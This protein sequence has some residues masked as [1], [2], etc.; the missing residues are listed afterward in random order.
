ML[1]DN[2]K[3]KARPVKNEPFRSGT[4]LRMPSQAARNVTRNK[5]SSEKTSNYRGFLSLAERVQI[6][7]GLIGYGYLKEA[8]RFCNCGRRVHKFRPEGMPVAYGIKETCKSR[9]CDRCAES[10]FRRFR[11]KGLDIISTLPRDGK[12]RVVFLTLTFKTRPLSKAYIRGCEKSVRKFVNVF[13]GLWLHRYNKKTGRHSKT[14]N[15]VSCG[16]VGVLEIG[17]SDNVHFHLLAYGYFHPIKFMSKIW[18]RITGDSYRI[19]VREVSQSTKDSPRLAISYI[20]KYIRKPPRF[21]SP[22]DYA[23]YLDLLKGIRRLHT[24]GVFYAHSGWQRDREPFECPFT[25]EKLWYDGAASPGEPVLSY[26][27]V[28][29]EV[30]RARSPG[31]LFELLKGVL[32]ENSGVEDIETPA[33]NPAFDTAKYRSPEHQTE[34]PVSRSWCYRSQ[35]I[36]LDTLL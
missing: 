28:A 24:Y 12:R 16:A 35:E 21:E 34:K 32:K 4:K 33:V 18:T 7:Q 22:G 25:G 2:G 36:V 9:I 8:D 3:A 30:A 20:L 19:D 27:V 10:M 17:P 31:V 29:D 13:Y 15:K 5:L 23:A 6:A 14:K 1:L 11:D 26:F